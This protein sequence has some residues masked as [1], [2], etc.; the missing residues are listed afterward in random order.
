MIIYSVCFLAQLFCILVSFYH[1]IKVFLFFFFFFLYIYI[2]IFLFL[3]FNILMPQNY[4]FW[5]CNFFFSLVRWFLLQV[6][7]WAV[8]GWMQSMWSYTNIHQ[9]ARYPA[10]QEGIYVHVFRSSNK[11]FVIT[12]LL[13]PTQ[14]YGW[15]FTM[16]SLVC[17]L[18][19]RSQQLPENQSLWS[20]IGYHINILARM[21]C[22]V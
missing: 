7:K 2:F 20:L 6:C 1:R 13:M 9:P 8:V 12:L 4:S 17:F 3:S 22:C 15:F 19:R 21:R 10:F 18:V 16:Y 11:H 14:L 5:R